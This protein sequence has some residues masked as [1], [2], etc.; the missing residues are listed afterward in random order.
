ME[1]G[2]EREGAREAS[3]TV[4]CPHCEGGVETIMH[5]DVFRYGAGE[6]A[7]DLAV[8]LPVR[9]CSSCGVEFLD[10]EAERVKQEALCR[11]FGVLTPW[12][13][14]EIRL[15]HGLSRAGFA[16]LTGLGEATLGRWEAGALIQTL[17]NDRYLRLL[18]E[19]GGI[20]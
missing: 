6:S 12:E 15:R 11:H 5:N 2:N 13:I 3:G 17:A 4:T 19:P 1:R 14:R 9:R 8:I 10:H 18:A 20:E 16:K 7:V